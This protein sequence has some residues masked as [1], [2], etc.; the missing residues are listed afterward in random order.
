GV[1]LLA[2][3]AAAGSGDVCDAL[4]TG[5]SACFCGA[6]A[7]A[8]GASAGRKGE[9]EI[10]VSVSRR[11][12]KRSTAAIRTPQTRP[13]RK[14]RSRPRGR[15]LSRPRGLSRSFS[16]AWGKFGVSGDARGPPVEA[17]NHAAHAAFFQEYGWA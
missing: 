2:G 1:R 7:A 17:T 10:I 9:R 6:G 4:V 16:V 14:R 8:T 3:V 13:K 15:R 5:V 11:P 12:P